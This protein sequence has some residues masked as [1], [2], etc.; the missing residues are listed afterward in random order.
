MVYTDYMAQKAKNRYDTG[1]KAGPTDEI[2][3]AIE[4]GIDI[5]MLIDN[6]RR[7]ST[8]RIRRHQTALNTAERLRKAKQV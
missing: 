6:I 2:Q 3:A 1:G 7:S 8:E 4:Y 5:S